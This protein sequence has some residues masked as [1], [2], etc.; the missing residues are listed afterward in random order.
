MPSIASLSDRVKFIQ[1]V[2]GRGRLANNSKN[3]DVRCPVCA[4]KD[5]AKLKLSIR[6]DDDRCHCWTCDFKAHTLLPLIRRFGS[7]EQLIEYIERFMPEGT[8]T[9]AKQQRCTTIDLL[10]EKL[11]LPV[12]FQLLTMAGDRDPDVLAVKRYA[13]LRGLS[14]DD[15]WRFRI[16]VSPDPRWKRRLIVPSF[17]A[18]GELNY[19]V[20]RAVDRWQRPKYDNPD[21]DKLPV[22]FNEMN[23]DWSKQLVLCEGAFDMFS[24][25]EN[26]VPLLGSDLNVGSATFRNI[27]LHNTPIALALD[28]DMWSTKTPKL[29][30]RLATYDVGVVIVDTRPFE[31]PGNATPVQFKAALRAAKPLDWGD[32]F[33][34]QLDNAS[35]TKLHI[36]RGIA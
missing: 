28:G 32:T 29:A 7:R 21:V 27:L 11:V 17:D 16:G 30:K 34:D 1:G 25:G 23:V 2:F 4:P 10:S 12:G 14:D 15:L 24:C 6:I 13:Q 33:R 19:F 5:R 9:F 36:Q 3:M 8:S 26:V 22:V 18:S 31:D 20:G 35:R